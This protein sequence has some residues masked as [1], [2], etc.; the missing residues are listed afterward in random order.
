[1]FEKL[2]RGESNEFAFRIVEVDKI[3][4][5]VDGLVWMD[6]SLL[7]FSVGGVLSKFFFIFV[8]LGMRSSHEVAQMGWGW[9]EYQNVGL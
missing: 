4:F 2:S 3:C 8:L 7:D 9:H 1:V 5:V 6:T